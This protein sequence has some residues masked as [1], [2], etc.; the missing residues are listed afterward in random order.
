MESEIA[1]LKGDTRKA[2]IGVFIGQIYYLFRINQIKFNKKFYPSNLIDRGY[3]FALI[4]LWLKAPIFF[5]FSH[6]LFHY[7][8]NIQSSDKIASKIAERHIRK[9]DL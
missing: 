4:N 9:Y 5:N 2:I 3:L 8:L 6:Q 7:V 1:G